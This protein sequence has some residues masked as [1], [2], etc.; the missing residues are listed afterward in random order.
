MLVQMT[1]IVNRVA[2]VRLCRH[3]KPASFIPVNFMDN[4]SLSS[5]LA[6]LIYMPS[7]KHCKLRARHQKA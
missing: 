2:V 6:I 5:P 3:A 7:M 4:V 1:V